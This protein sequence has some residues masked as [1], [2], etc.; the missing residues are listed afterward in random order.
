MAREY[1]SRRGAC[2]L[3]EISCQ[4]C[5][6][7]ETDDCISCPE[8]RLFDDGRCVIRCESG[9][10]AAGGRARPRS[11]V[12]RCRPGLGP[13]EGRCL[14]LLCGDDGGCVDHCE[15]GFFLDAGAQECERCG[16]VLSKPAG[17]AIRRLTASR[18]DRA[19]ACV[20]LQTQALCPDKQFNN[21]IKGR[22]LGLNVHF[23]TDQQS[24]VSRCPSA[25][26]ANQTS[27]RCQSCP[28]G[29]VSCQDSLG[30]QRCRRGAD[31]LYLQDGHCVSDCDRGFPVEE[32]CHP[33]APECASCTL[34][35][36][37]C[38]SCAPQRL[39]L[40]ASC[41]AQCPA[42]FYATRDQCLPCPPDCTMCNEDGLCQEC[43]EDFFLH[44]DRC[45]ADCPGGYFASEWECV[46]CH[47]DCGRCD[48]PDPDDCL[49]C[50][51]PRAVLHS[52][53]CLGECPSRT[54][55]DQGSREC[56]DSASCLTCDGD[57]RLD[58]AGRCVWY[59]RCSEHTYLDPEGQCLR[60]HQLCLRCSGPGEGQCLAC[61]DTHFLLDGG[62]VDHCESGFFL[63]AGAQECERCDASC[64]T[65]GGPRYDDCDLCEDGFALTAGACV[66]L[67]TQALCPDK[68]FNNDDGAL[69]CDSCYHGYNLLALGAGGLCES[70]CLL[71]FYATDQESDSAS[72][73][74]ACVPCEP[75][76]LG[77]RGPSRWDCMVC[78]SLQLLSEDGRCMSCCRNGKRAAA[79][80]AE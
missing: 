34:S 26:F 51:N 13:R 18:L 29:C 57:R 52:G 15:S 20:A 72:W 35:A 2:H 60:C 40:N 45:V 62:C 6:G 21:G 77:C 43:S 68:Q 54:F 61:N 63:D 76:C 12:L 46:R 73:R 4:R 78:P 59:S 31:R 19:G 79:G 38:L 5:L 37:H 66:A 27:G 1:V 39:L 53:E 25:T 50:R 42:G 7:P 30:C 80:L 41:L 47:G 49:E 65:C 14:P 9:R 28:P 8:S 70:Q 74:S 55:H 64:Q 3:C 17:A 32:E 24:C 71:G 58:A 11:S 10:Y 23:L 16:R 69:A 56:L 33:C 22:A 67:Q 36:S 44:E 75:S 48:G